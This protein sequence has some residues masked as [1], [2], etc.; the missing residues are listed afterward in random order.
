MKKNN[1]L[2][3]LS[4]AMILGAVL[5]ADI[6][7]DYKLIANGIL[8]NNEKIKKLEEDN[9]RLHKEIELLRRYSSVVE[10]T[11]KPRVLDEDF[12]DKLKKISDRK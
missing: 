1:I 10:K 6:Y 3:V 4:G 7:D 5:H 8:I 2:K 11:A 12:R 9:R